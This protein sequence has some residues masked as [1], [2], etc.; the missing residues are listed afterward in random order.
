V[1][2]KEASLYTI[3]GSLRRVESKLANIQGFQKDNASCYNATATSSPLESQPGQDTDRAHNQIR[4]TETEGPLEN[5]TNPPS[6][7]RSP[8]S[9]SAHQVLFWPAVQELLPEAVLSASCGLDRNYS[10]ELEFKRQVLTPEIKPYAEDAEGDWLVGLSLSVIRELSDAYFL[11]FNLVS[12]LI[13]RA[14]FFHNILGSVI[15]RGFGNDIEACLVLVV[16]ALGCFGLKF[17]NEAK[18]ESSFDRSQPGS[19]FNEANYRQRSAKKLNS[20]LDEEV[21][22]LGF[23]N[24]SRKRI[25]F[26]NCDNSPQ[27]SQYYFLSAYVHQFDDVYC[28]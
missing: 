1:Y 17:R 14:F 8:I 19:E 13:D 11:T 10:T 24:E 2:S 22:G 28:S 16:L 25:G 21:T 5:I 3:I 4:P 20:L 27:S 15:D 9:F 26:L 7:T 18:R 6:S 12:P 23:F